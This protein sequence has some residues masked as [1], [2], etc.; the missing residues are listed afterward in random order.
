MKKYIA[1]LISIVP[2]NILRV[3]LYNI[4]MGYKISYS[5]KIGIGT[6]I[7]SRTVLINKV[8]I[9]MFNK[10]IGEFDLV[11]DQG[12]IIGSFNEFSSVPGKNKSAYCEIGKNT[13]ITKNHLFDTSGGIT[14]K[15]HTCIAGQGSQLWT[16]GGQKEQKKIVINKKCY[17]GSAV[18]IAQGVEIAEN[19]YIGL[20][21]V[22]IDTFNE[23]DVLILGFPAK[24]VKKN[25]IARKSLE[26][27]NI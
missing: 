27:K 4:F 22:V 16:H 11:V 2:L 26:N 8:R 20:G 17:I 10:F 18:R 9:G 5:S 19:S 15:D 23:P 21:S 6:I 3:I 13:L 14:I 1:L 7:A 12:T 25:I 24:I